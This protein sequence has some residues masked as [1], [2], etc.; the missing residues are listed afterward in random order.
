VKVNPLATWTDDDVAY[1][2]KAERT[3]GASAL[4]S[5]LRVD[6][7][8]RGDDQAGRRRVTGVRVVGSAR[9]RGVRPARGLTSTKK[10]AF[11]VRWT[12]MFVRSVKELVR[13]CY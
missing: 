9:Q 7:L 4:G 11:A 13:C 12:S 2:L 6:R 10:T 5:G 8:R 3:R 1:Y